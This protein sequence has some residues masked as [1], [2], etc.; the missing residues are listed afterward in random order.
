MKRKSFNSL[1]TKIVLSIALVSIV[2][3]LVIFVLSNK[4]NKEAFH[5]IEIEKANIIAQTIEP[6]IALNMY[7]DM[8]DKINQITLQLIE[9]PNI[10]AVKVLKNDNIINYVESKEHK[11]EVEESFV[12]KRTI[13][14]PN[15]SQ[16]IGEL[17]LIY[18]NKGYKKLISKYTDL[19]ALLILSLVILLALFGVYVKKLLYPLRQIS[20]LLKNYSPNKNIEIPFVSQNNEIGLISGAL[21]NMQ[22]K[23]VQYSKKQENINHYLEEKVNEKT[24]ELRAQLYIDTLTGLPN[25]FSMFNDIVETDDGALLIINID[26]FKEINDFFGHIAGDIVLKKFSNRLKNMFKTN[27]FAKLKRLSGD[28]FALLFVQKPPLQ[29]FI[30]I[31]H[32]LIN[33]VEKMIFFN[34]NNEISI[35]V[36]VGGAYQIDGGLEK[37]DIALKSAKKQQKSFLLYDENLNIEGQYKENMEWVKKLKRAI[38]HDMIVPYYQPIF[39][40]ITDK[41]ASFECLVRLIDDEGK[42]ISPYLFLNVA[43]KSRLYST[44]TKIMIEKSCMHFENLE[45]DFSVNLSVE[46]ILDADTVN[47][48]KAKIIQHNVAN[49]IIFEIL[50]SEGIENYEEVSIFTQEMKKLGCRIAIDDFGSGYSNFEHLLKLNIDYIKIDGSLIENLDKDISAQLI[51]ETIVDFAKRLN[52]LTVAEFVHNSDVYEKVKELNVNRTQGY[53]LSEPRKSANKE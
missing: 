48:I 34:D 38:E 19:T 1:S 53:F 36:T 16:A 9:N 15:S 17:V 51:V 29:E 31:A 6:L 28:E 12:V 11:E 4:I 35:R 30:K 25:R 18:S 42:V 27:E 23:I 10:L 50:E 14:Q 44:L 46:D 41:I 33:D 7:L 13:T 2:I 45:Y 52:I 8:E 49:R 32:K 37:A 47:Y 24:L 3:T 20:K 22:K 39:D 40:N 43:K 5:Q 21:N 26:D